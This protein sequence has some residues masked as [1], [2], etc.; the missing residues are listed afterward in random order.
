MSPAIHA[1]WLKE[2]TNDRPSN[3]HRPRNQNCLACDR[4]ADKEAT[5]RQAKQN[6]T[7]NILIIRAFKRSHSK[8]KTAQIDFEIRSVVAR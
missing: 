6:L 3:C 4:V 1:E 7:P 5:E 2:P 8:E